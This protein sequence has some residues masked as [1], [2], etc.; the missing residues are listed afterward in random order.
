MLQKSKSAI[1]QPGSNFEH[2][3][4]VNWT[5]MAVLTAAL[6][7]I[8]SVAVI[9]TACDNANP[10]TVQPPIVVPDTLRYDIRSAENFIAQFPIINNAANQSNT[11]VIIDVASIAV[12]SSQIDPI[13]TGVGMLGNTDRTDF[14]DLHGFI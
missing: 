11:F 3:N 14:A 5:K 10:L 7:C 4:L 6:I 1:T 2:K 12:A 8:A 9:F 13:G